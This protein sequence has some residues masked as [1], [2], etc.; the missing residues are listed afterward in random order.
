MAALFRKHLSQVEKWISEQSNVQV[1]YVSYNEMIADPI[2]EI[3]RIHQFLG[4]E[5]D[6]EK[7]VSVIDR[8]L[9]R[10]RSTDS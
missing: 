8:T 9:Y 4:N 7:M 3:E 6:T 5:L 10:Q 2:K 1:L